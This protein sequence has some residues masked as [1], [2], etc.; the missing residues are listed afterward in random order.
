MKCPVC[1]CEKFF[2]KDPED[3]YETYEIE[4]KAGLV[5]F[6]DPDEAEAGDFEIEAGTE[7]YC[8]KC[9]WHGKVQDL[10]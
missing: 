5:A 10:K 2:V 4:M 7:A 1:R 9:T 6:C 8:D 3:E